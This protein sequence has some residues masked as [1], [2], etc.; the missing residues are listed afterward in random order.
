V[1]REERLQN[2]AFLRVGQVPR[3][4]VGPLRHCYDR[5]LAGVWRRERVGEWSVLWTRAVKTF[6]PR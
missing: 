2:G 6:G 5:P 1:D 3:A 4:V